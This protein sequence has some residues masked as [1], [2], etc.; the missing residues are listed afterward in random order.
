[1][2][3]VDELAQIA[4]NHTAYQN[5]GAF[6]GSAAE[7]A[8]GTG[9][10]FSGVTYP[11]YN[12]A[13]ARFEARR[14][15]V[16]IL[17]HECD[18]DQQNVREFNTGFVLAPLIAMASF[19]RMFEQANRHDLARNLA[20][21]VAGDRVSRLFFLPPPNPLLPANGMGLGAFIYL[22]AITSGHVKQLSVQEAHKVCAL[23]EYGLEALD[24]KLRNHFLR[25][26]A[27]QLAQLR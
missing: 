8:P 11:T 21:D 2:S 6:Y 9:L 23:S 18:I 25:P 14:G 27:Q 24:R 3:F 26:T 13:N 16:L 10:I 15:A 4:L 17:T 22:N 20:R 12:P 19:A 7:L 5:I 1:M